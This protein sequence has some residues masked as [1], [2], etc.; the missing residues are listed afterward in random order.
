MHQE[1][2]LRETVEIY[3]GGRRRKKD[4][5]EGEG[6]G[7]KKE[8][9]TFVAEH[10]WP[11][12]PLNITTCT[13]DLARISSRTCNGFSIVYLEFCL[14]EDAGNSYRLESSIISVYSFARISPIQLQ[15]QRD[16]VLAACCRDTRSGPLHPT[17][18]VN[19]SGGS[20][21]CTHQF[22]KLHSA[23]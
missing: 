7:E 22:F 21:V 13:Q 16:L 8:R 3:G 20:S 19:A 14:Y 6:E 12:R 11:R 2:L 15:F 18:V 10:N 17:N 23:Q 9:P 5:E 4:R 1:V